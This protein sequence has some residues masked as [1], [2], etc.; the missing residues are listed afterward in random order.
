MLLERAG[1]QREGVGVEEAMVAVMDVLL[2]EM[3]WYLDGKK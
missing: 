3:H 2:E 1:E